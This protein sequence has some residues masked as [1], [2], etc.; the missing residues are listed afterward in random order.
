LHGTLQGDK[1]GTLD[2]YRAADYK[3]NNDKVVTKVNA[4]VLK[5]PLADRENVEKIAAIIKVENFVDLVSTP[6]TQ[7]RVT[8]KALV[9]L[10][11]VAVDNPNK[12]TIANALKKADAASLN[13]IEKIQEAIKAEL[14]AV[15]ERKDLLAE[16]KA[17]IAARKK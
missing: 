8:S 6:A 17:R 11:L 12:T 9:E 7:K 3:V 1:P 13:S 4:A 10:G 14:A 2:Q 15:K 16:I 5:L